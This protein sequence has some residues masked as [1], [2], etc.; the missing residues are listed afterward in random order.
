MPRDILSEYGP[1]AN[2]PQA[3]RAGSGGVKTARDVMNYQPPWGPKG[4]MDP[5]S[6]GIH[7]NNH[8]NARC[9]VADRGGGGP[10][11]GGTVHRSGSQRG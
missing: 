11:I 10:G 8:G 7:G 2:K 9:P 1:D 4:I 5:E 6:P 3:P